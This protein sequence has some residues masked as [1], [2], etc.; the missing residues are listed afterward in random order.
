MENKEIDPANKGNNTTLISKKKSNHEDLSDNLRKNLLRRK[1]T[2][3][4]S[5]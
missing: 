2:K 4:N 1:A 5:S 3:S